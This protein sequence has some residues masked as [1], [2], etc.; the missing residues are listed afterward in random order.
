MTV[1]QSEYLS[2][3]E[4]AKLVRKALKA[5][6]PHVTFR[7]L[8]KTYSMGA[9][10]DVAW[11][12]GPRAER[13]KAITDPFEGKSF[14]GMI[15]LAVANRHYIT[16]DGVVGYAG[17]QGTE[18]S[19]GTIAPV[20]NE[21]PEGARVVRFLADYIFPQRQVSEYDTKLAE[22]L[23]HIRENCHTEGEEPDDRFANDWV[24]DLAGRMVFDRDE[25]EDVEAAFKRIVLRWS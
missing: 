7:V 5:A 1:Q 6:F 14:D 10:I 4:T 25:T 9:S 17:T 12:D 11:E 16:A 3:A 20:A 19:H 13:V 21:I 23:A 15:D 22:A 2:C 8:S 24:R 18:G